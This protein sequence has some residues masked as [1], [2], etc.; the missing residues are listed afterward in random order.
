MSPH[1]PDQ[2]SQGLQISGV[3]LL[4]CFSKGGLLSEWVSDKV[5]YWAVG[6][7]AKKKKKKRWI[8]KDS[9][10]EKKEKI[11]IWERKK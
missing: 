7:T 4:L 9:E 3:T 2:M 11:N 1:H 8:W 5:T 6:W 10:Y